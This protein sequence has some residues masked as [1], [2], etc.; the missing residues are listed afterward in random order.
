MARRLLVLLCMLVMIAS[1]GVVS[2]QA[3]EPNAWTTIEANLRAQPSRNGVVIQVLPAETPLTLEARSGSSEWVLASKLD[4]TARGWLA[5]KLLRY[6]AGVRVGNLTVS[7]E[8]V[9]AA[10]A[11]S[12]GDQMLDAPLPSGSAPLDAPFAPKI[13]PQIKSAM[14][15]VF[16]R[17][18][19]LG[20]N[21]RV[22]SKVGDCQTDHHAFL[23]EIGYGNYALGEYA[24]LQ[25]VIDWFSVAPRENTHNSFDLQS[26]AS[27]NGFNSSAVTQPEFANP[28]FCQAG[29]QP[30]DCELRINKPAVAIIMFGTADVN[31]MVPQQYRSFLNNIVTKTLKAGVIPILSTFPEMNT[32]PER[33]RQINQIVISTAARYSLPLV[34]LEGALA[35]L[36]DHGLESNQTY[37]TV[38]PNFTFN[39]S[40]LS[41]GYSVRNLLTLQALDMVWRE[42]IR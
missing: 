20:N 11:S 14:K 35:A 12:G 27:S 41:Y 4:G 9:V 15:A 30:L 38:P 36:P 26:V 31:V 10:G 16:A 32:Y 8:E 19:A 17:G 24:Y 3:Q 13:T 37:M 1:T 18:Q 22:F 39:A 40:D 34:N 29:E 28:E 25:S 7:Q 5:V 21:P 2:V 23:K 6:A 33:S 42:I